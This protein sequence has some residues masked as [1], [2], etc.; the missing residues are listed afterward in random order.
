MA[1]AVLQHVTKKKLAKLRDQQTKFSKNTAALLDFDDKDSL[2]YSRRLLDGIKKMD[3]A[4]PGLSLANVELF[5][6]QA[7]HDAS[8]P[9]K[10]IAQ[11]RAQLEKVLSVRSDNFAFASLY[12]QLVTEWLEKPNEANRQLSDSSAKDDGFEPVGREEMHK[13]RQTW[14]SIV[15]SDRARVDLDALKTFLSGLFG[16]DKPAVDAA[17]V[18]P[19]DRLRKRMKRFSVRPLTTTTLKASINGVI[20]SDLFAG[21]KRDA[22]LD[23]KERESVLEEVVDVLNMSLKPL[24]DWTWEQA[25]I[26]IIQRRQ[27]NGKYR[28]FMDEELHQALLVHYIGALMA[29]HAKDA[30][31]TFRSEAW[32]TTSK[33]KMSPEDIKR[34]AYYLQETQARHRMGD[35]TVNLNKPG[36]SIET[37]REVE[38]ADQYFLTQMPGGIEDGTRDYN[39]DDDEEDDSK[40]K[41]P[42]ELKQ[43]LMELLT[44]D[45][46]LG[47]EVQGEFCVFQSD[48]TWFGPSLPHA[49]ILAVLRFFG[50]KDYIISF[51]QAFLETPLVFAQD[52]PDAVPNTRKAGAPMSHALSDVFGELILFCLDFAVN[53]ATQGQK[54]Y[55]M[56]DDLWFWGSPKDAQT[57]WQVIQEFTAVTGLELNEDKTGSVTVTTTGSTPNSGLIP[58]GPIKWGF[59]VLSPTT[60]KW[61]IDL[62]QVHDHIAELRLQ[63]E[64]CNSVFS[65]VQA[66]NSYV[67]RFFTTNFGRASHCHGPS[68]LRSVISTFELIQRELFP[69]GSVTAHIKSMISTRFDIP[70]SSIPTGFLYFP[71]ELGGLDLRNPFIPLLSRLHEKPRVST[72]S[73]S[74]QELENAASN[75]LEPA[76][77][78]RLAYLRDKHDYDR[79]RARFDRDKATLASVD[80]WAPAPGEPFFSFEEYTRFRTETSFHLLTEAEKLRR[81]PGEVTIAQEEGMSV[82]VDRVRVRMGATWWNKG[83]NRWIVGLYGP[84]M[85]E[86]FGG[87]EVGD[88]E[89]LPVG[90]VRMLK[91]EKVRWRG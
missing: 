65:F 51:C 57:A 2:E 50:F 1:T 39:G 62:A 59:L 71:T 83:Y 16:T 82:Y 31:T 17:D 46:L 18:T 66:W 76:E 75:S 19:F 27:V 25:A 77:R 42:V 40:G 81:Q 56:H 37:L 24:Q 11:W 52:G 67:S 10:T 3:L 8:V 89:L 69:S 90:L 28:F 63:L 32:S 15:F 47:L 91:G 38:F 80:G 85:V 21:D 72:E 20:R 34:R 58:S 73:Q 9:S 84:E 61:E 60:R 86:V 41:T 36:Q 48:F 6:K 54:L 29:S 44:V 43:E 55:R 4:N 23:L 70:T 14:E 87:L 7:E 78:L 45:M 35:H 13:Q 68:H 33:T 88:R 74:L 30:L 5:L 53:R 49:T 22:L 26:P 64:A 79:A 12:G